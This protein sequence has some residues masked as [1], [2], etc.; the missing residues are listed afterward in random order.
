MG[1]AIFCEGAINV[2]PPNV[3]RGRLV[4]KAGVVFVVLPN[5]DVCDIE[6]DD[7]AAV[8][9]LAPPKADVEAGALLALA[10]AANADVFAPKL[11]GVCVAENDEMGWLNIDVA[12]GPV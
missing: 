11:D 2:E 9:F 12:A 4:P 3:E 1:A 6:P 7:G 8:C 5:A 10:L